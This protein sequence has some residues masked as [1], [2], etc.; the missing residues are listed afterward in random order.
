LVDVVGV[1]NTEKRILLERIFPKNRVEVSNDSRVVS[2]QTLADLVRNDKTI[3]IFESATVDGFKGGKWEEVKD[4]VIDGKKAVS[5]K[6]AMRIVNFE[7]PADVPGLTTMTDDNDVYIAQKLN[8]IIMLSTSLSNLPDK[9]LEM[10]FGLM[11]YNIISEEDY[12]ITKLQDIYKARVGNTVIDLQNKS[13]QEEKQMKE[14]SNAFMQHLAQKINYDRTILGAGKYDE[15]NLTKMTENI[16][17]IFKNPH[18]ESVELNGDIITI[19][20]KNLM[21]GIW[22]I[23]QYSISYD[24]KS[25]H[26]KIKRITAPSFPREK[27]VYIATRDA[28]DSGSG[29]MEH[30]HVKDGSPCTGNFGEMIE[31]FWTRDFL[32]GTIMAVQYLRSYSREGGPH[33]GFN[34]WLASIGYV[35]DARKM[36]VEEIYQVDNGVATFRNTSPEATTKRLKELGITALKDKDPNAVEKYFLES[37]SGKDSRLE[38]SIEYVDWRDKQKKE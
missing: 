27:G 6:N 11:G 4:I 16:R 17:K 30:P 3:Y 8:N 24:P 37:S 20:T 35:N 31:S 26:P 1:G 34:K 15:E 5:K 25:T 19:V 38:P 2:K 18:V 7:E 23:G 9:F 33:Y 10:L 21:M 36:D 14:Y 13:K 22:D 29:G 32:T 12:V 28:W